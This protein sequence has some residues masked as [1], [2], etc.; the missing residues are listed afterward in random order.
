MLEQYQDYSE[1]IL[2]HISYYQHTFYTF[3][4]KLPSFYKKQ[5]VQNIKKMDYNLDDKLRPGDEFI[6][7]LNLS[8]E[9][10]PSDFKG[11]GNLSHAL[12]KKTLLWLLFNITN[13]TLKS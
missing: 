8:Q 5:E 9:K 12:P 7:L 13:K 1:L 6:F 4:E 2:D 11:G 3:Q 10:L